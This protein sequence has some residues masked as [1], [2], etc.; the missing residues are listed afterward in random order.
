MKLLR[1]FKKGDLFTCNVLYR[2]SVIRDGYIVGCIYPYNVGIA[3]KMSSSSSTYGG[4]LYLVYINNIICDMYE[5]FMK[6]I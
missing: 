3:I 4:D 1:K 6:K 5:H 2:T